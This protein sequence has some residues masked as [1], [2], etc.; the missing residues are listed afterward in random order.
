MK[1]TRSLSEF[2]WPSEFELLDFTLDTKEFGLGFIFFISKNSAHF[3]VIA[4]FKIPFN[5]KIDKRHF[6]LFK[7]SFPVFSEL[8][9][10]HWTEVISGHLTFFCACSENKNCSYKILIL[11]K[12]FV[13]TLQLISF[14]DDW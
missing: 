6:A 1:Q 4:F 14:Q 7:S 11:K 9:N 12:G 8:G 3:S 10:I 13:E 5:F 2:S